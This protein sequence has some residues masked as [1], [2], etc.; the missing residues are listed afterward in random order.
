[1]EPDTVVITTTLLSFAGGLLSWIFF[2]VVKPTLK[3]IDKHE[4]LSESIDTI[5]KEITTNG[6][7]SLKDVV[8]K[9]GDTCGRIEESQR[10]IEQRSKAALHYNS[11]ALF[12]TDNAGRLV[13]TNESFNELTGKSTDSLEGRD[14]I[15]YVHEDEREDFIHEL[16]SCLS[17]N[18][19]LDKETK[20]SDDMD[21]RIVGFPYKLNEDEQGG[22]LISVSEISQKG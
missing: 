9:L 2:K 22:F 5:K 8:C 11:T 18:R 16:N 13:W 1:M 6:G 17:M 15:T 19:R 12:E 20:T 14:W 3:F 4:D 10:I 21:V 7:G